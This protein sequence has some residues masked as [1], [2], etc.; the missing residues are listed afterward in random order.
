M[1]RGRVDCGLR[2]VLPRRSGSEVVVVDFIAMVMAGR[3]AVF[4]MVVKKVRMITVVKVI[5][6]FTETV[7]VVLEVVTIVDLV[8]E[9]KVRCNSICN[10]VQISYSSSNNFSEGSSCG[11][12]DSCNSKK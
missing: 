8:E 5:T 4:V 10:N 7:V 12:G 3:V 9:M 1:G 2:I 6:L 11:K